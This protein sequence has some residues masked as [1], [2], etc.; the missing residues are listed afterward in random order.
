MGERIGQEYALK[1]ENYKITKK[2]MSTIINQDEKHERLEELAWALQEIM[3]DIKTAV[4]IYNVLTTTLLELNQMGLI[5]ITSNPPTVH[6]K[7]SLNRLVILPI[8]INLCKLDELTNIY[9]KDLK[10]CLP[11]DIHLSL[12]DVK[13]LIQD[14]KMYEFRSKYIAHVKCKTKNRP[15]TVK[16]A[17]D[18]LCKVLNIEYSPVDYKTASFKYFLLYIYDKT[19]K[20]CVTSIIE[21]TIS[22][23]SQSIGG[24]KPRYQCNQ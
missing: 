21:S 19:N 20:K 7:M 9:G 11:K 2:P 13:K 5:E 1:T 14:R 4:D 16:E 8:I 23:I 18:A 24:L 3:I 22:A 10:S 17:T 6:E 15:L 12:N